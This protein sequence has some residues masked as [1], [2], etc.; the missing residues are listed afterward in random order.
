MQVRPSVAGFTSQ[1]FII[2]IMSPRA[3]LFL[4][5][6]TNGGKGVQVGGETSDAVW[7]RDRDTEKKTGGR[8]GRHGDVEVLFGNNEDD[9]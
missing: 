7:F 1:T 9:G 3:V 8:A 6:S 4:S 5:I 2:T